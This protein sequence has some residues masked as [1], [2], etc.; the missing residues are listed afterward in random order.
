M[1]TYI[2]KRDKLFEARFS[3]QDARLFG[4]SNVGA[5]IVADNPKEAIDIFNATLRPGARY[6]SNYLCAKLTS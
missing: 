6:S 4:E 1:S 2:I 3:A 5:R